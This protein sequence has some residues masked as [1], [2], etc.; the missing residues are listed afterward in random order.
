[1][2]QPTARQVRLGSILRK[3]REE[4]G[5]GSQDALARS[6]GWSESK[7]SR[8][9]SGRLGI[10]EPDL[11]VLLD[12]YCV[13]DQALRGYV[14]DLRRRGNTRGWDTDIRSVVSAVYADYIGYES[15]AAEAS[16]VE[17]VL[18]PGLLQTYDY[19]A[20]VLD[21]HLPDIGEQER[22]ERLSIRQKRQAIF[23][24]P[25]PLV[26]WCV[27]S[28]SVLRH[29]I[30]PPAIMAAQLDH[31]LTLSHDYPDTINLHILPEE[32]ASHGAIFGPFV[33]LSFAQR[34]EP[35]IVYLEQLTGN[36]FL[37]ETREVQAYGRL[38]KRLMMKDSLRRPESLRLI[39]AHRDTYRKG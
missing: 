35:D 28:E 21:Q 2:D 4:G 15:D 12:R 11:T 38:F 32:S 10:A 37:E 5:H 31:L 39:R 17:P 34:W 6:L 22:E 25:A 14:R 20:A 8:I 30:G 36:R 26:V 1:M 19:A 13:Q 16:S 29:A 27:V 23:D 7:L 33:I 9:E 24:R 18:I 3:L